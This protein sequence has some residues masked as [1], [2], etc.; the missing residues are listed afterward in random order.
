MRIELPIEELAMGEIA[1]PMEPEHPSWA[2]LEEWD[3]ALGPM[4]GY[5][6][7]S[8]KSRVEHEGEPAIKF[9]EGA[10]L[11]RT[12]MVGDATW[13]ELTIECRMQALQG[14]AGPTNDDCEV[15]RARCGPVVRADTSRRL[16]WFCLEGRERLVLYRRIDQEWHQLAAEPVQYAGDVI[17]LRVELDADGMRAECPELGV[18]MRATDTMIATGR[19]GFRSLGASRLFE[20]TVSMSAS[21]QQTNERPA[22]QRRSVVAAHGHSV[23]GAVQVDEITLPEGHRLV[24][25][26]DLRRTGEHDLLLHGPDGLVATDWCGTDLWRYPGPVAQTK[27]SAEPIEG[28]WRLYVLCG[29]HSSKRDSSVRGDTSESVV[30]SQVAVLDA[31]TGEELV[32][33]E[34]PEDPHR[35]KLRMYDFSF[36]TGRLVSDA[37]ADIIVRNWRTDLGHGGRDLWAFDGELHL[38]WHAEVDPPYGHSNAVHLVDLTGDGRDEVVAGG[39]VLAAD[40]EVISVHDLAHEMDEIRGAHHYDAVAVGHMADDPERDPVALL[41]AG[42]AGVYVI[43]PLTGRTRAA[44]RVGHAQGVQPCRLRDDLPGTQALAHTRWGNM[45]ILTLLSGLG[46]RLWTMQPSFIPMSTP[47]QWLPD[48]PQHLW[49]NSTRDVLGLYDGHA[50]CVHELPA[51][52]AA[53]GDRPPT[54]VRASVM[55]READGQDLLA[56]T[57]DGRILLFGRE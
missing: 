23:P 27:L 49:V 33:R 50:R 1:P 7:L 9:A 43:D 44:H 6:V 21:Q 36:E 29:C 25:A 28:R 42:S 37:A 47:V 16:Y 2:V 19:A 41:I 24:Q 20:L 57:M 22:A 10:D 34:L 39:T 12:L 48:G 55:R 52:R 3:D 15:T 35:D 26:A 51:V 40:G 53:W 54:Q 14:A 8:G 13:R 38:L 18:V 30:A 31:T 46:D 56:L 32:R 11:E 4:G 5:R 17:T 45:G